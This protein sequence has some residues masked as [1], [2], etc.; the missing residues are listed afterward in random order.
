MYDVKESLATLMADEPPFE[1]AGTRLVAVARGRRRTRI[2]VS[3][4]VVASVAAAVGLGVGVTSSHPKQQ[5]AGPGD[6]ATAMPGPRD[7]LAVKTEIFNGMKSRLVGIAQAY[8]TTYDLAVNSVDGTCCGDPSSVRGQ[9]RFS[10]S[11]QHGAVRSLLNVTADY[12]PG[13]PLVV[14]CP[15]NAIVACDRLSEG[16]PMA[17]IYAGRGPTSDTGRV[18]RFVREDGTV[19]TVTADD[20]GGPQSPTLDVFMYSI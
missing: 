5:A 2:G 11:L 15:A 12:K 13:E 4:L 16:E 19:V 1:L 8:S 7:P 14:A 18:L 10:V 17:Y 6:S 9:Y 20:P 3:F